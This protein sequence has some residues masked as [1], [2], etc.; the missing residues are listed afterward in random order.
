[1]GM[2]VLPPPNELGD[3]VVRVA[4]DP[5]WPIPRPE[6]SAA[7]EKANLHKALG[8][9]LA[10]KGTGAR[11]VY[12]GTADSPIHDYAPDIPIEVVPLIEGGIA[13]HPEWA[14]RAR[15]DAFYGAFYEA[16][17]REGAHAVIV[18]GDQQSFREVPA[19]AQALPSTRFFCNNHGLGPHPDAPRAYERCNGVVRFVAISH[20]QVREYPTIQHAG[21][22]YNSLHPDEFRPQPEPV[23][24]VLE[25]ADRPRRLEAGYALFVGRMNR[26]K[27]ADQAIAMARA[28]GIR[29]VMA[30][31]L[32]QR[33][34]DPDF[35]DLELRPEIDGDRV[36]YLGELGPADLDR[37]YRG[38][39]CLLFPIQWEEPFGLVVVEAMARGVP[40]IA[41]PRGAMPELI[42][43]G[44]SGY[45]VTSVEEGATRA[46]DA[47]AHVDRLACAARA[48]ARFSWE[49]TG[50]DYLDLIWRALHDE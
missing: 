30:G 32:A 26:E 12:Y 18:G 6:G 36:I 3:L 38:A 8:I 10:L 29:L 41:T 27:G 39:S 47:I 1:M 44:I 11:V 19:L 4:N 49:V 33:E 28:A 42:E 24:C 46:Q 14:T 7:W 43:P 31:P 50:H 17:V 16:V 21:V 2:T 23:D 25:R 40:V 48:R 13:E 37:A 45:L 5:I 9:A 20:A 34:W 35:Y 15:E 22:V